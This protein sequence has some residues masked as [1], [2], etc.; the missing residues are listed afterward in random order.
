MIKK[1]LSN[2]VILGSS[3]LSKGNVSI[4]NEKLN[5]T[6]DRIELDH[7]LNYNQITNCILS[8]PNGVAT[9]SGKTITVKQ[10]LKVLIPNGRNADRTLNNIEYVVHS[11]ATFTY[12]YSSLIPNDKVFIKD[13]NT[14][15]RLQSEYVYRVKSYSQLSTDTGTNQYRFAF[16]DDDNLWYFTSNTGADWNVYKTAQILNCSV[17][18]DSIITSLTLYQPVELLKRTDKEEITSWGV[19][20]YAKGVQGVTGLN[21]WKTVDKDVLVSACVRNN[22]TRT[23]VSIY[24][25]D[26]LGNPVPSAYDSII[27][28]LGMVNTTTIYTGS[29]GLGLTPF[30]NAVVPKGCSYQ[31]V[32]DF[33]NFIGCIEYPLKGVSE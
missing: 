9:Y 6:Q 29:A 18:A 23:G 14:I 33:A 8:A 28:N 17:G 15:A 3:S 11:D 27:D 24:V 19:P 5:Q 10:G 25:K 32:N 26:V 22:N 20:D 1:K 2:A 16:V 21:V 4:T 30:C 31:L 7:R 13:D 12:P